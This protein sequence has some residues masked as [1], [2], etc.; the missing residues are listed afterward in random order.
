MHDVHHL[1]LL[2]NQTV[3]GDSIKMKM[4][5]RMD[6]SYIIHAY[7]QKWLKKLQKCCKIFA[8]VA[9]KWLIFV[10]VAAKVASGFLK[11]NTYMCTQ[12]PSVLQIILSRAIKL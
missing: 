10:K 3:L 1:S 11:L 8:K 12:S 2:I 4:K 7:L 9:A 6:N 5:I